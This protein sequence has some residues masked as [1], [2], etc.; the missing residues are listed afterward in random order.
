MNARPKGPGW[1]I[2]IVFVVGCAGD[3]LNA[4]PSPPPTIE[5][6]TVEASP[7]NVLSAVV[8]VRVRDA[9]SVAVRFHSAD[10]TTGDSATPAVAVPDGAGVIV[11]PILGLFAERRYSLRAVAFGRGGETVG[12]AL[13]LTTDTLPSELPR[14]VAT[15]SDPEPGYIVFGAGRYGLAIDNTGRVVW[16]Y[17]FPV[18]PG[19]DFAAQ[20]GKYYAR[21]PTPAPSDLSEWIEIDPLGNVT[22]TLGCRAGL[23]PRYHDVIVQSGGDYWLMC[24]ETR[25]MDLSSVGGVVG[26]RVIGTNIQHISADGTLLFQ[27]SPFDHFDIA[28]GNPRDLTGPVVNWT[29][30][31][32][33]D[34][35]PDGGLL[36]SFRNLSEITKIDT[37]TGRVIWR[38]GGRRNQ[39]RILEASQAGFAGQHSVRS[40]PTGGIMILDNV[41]NPSESNG[42][43]YVLDERTMSARLTGLYSSA[44]RV[45]TEIGGSVQRLPHGHTLVSFGTA[46][47]V[48][49]F[50]GENVAWQIEGNAGYVFR[51]QRIPSLYAPGVGASR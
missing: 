14:Y 48:I 39:F 9:D 27:W 3:P 40:D 10:V 21:R 43:E 42:E 49:E 30:G 29:H 44:P 46:G 5:Q 15:G 17:R 50:D 33:I 13:E 8:R 23:S 28:D 16:Y 12:A 4:T 47:R 26:A 18:S 19:L 34:L 51:A 35:A 20:A 32:A 41:G 1:S 7:V 24:D 37:A 22:R 2:V 6:G 38:F 31:N 25:T 11:V 36:A 45:V